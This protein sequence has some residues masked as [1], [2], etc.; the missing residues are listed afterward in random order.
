MNAC[1]RAQSCNYTFLGHSS[2]D[3]AH[4]GHEEDEDDETGDDD[5]DEC[6]PPLD[7]DLHDPEREQDDGDHVGEAR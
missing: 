6:V 2:V 7:Q 3:E 5:E 1:L 4:V